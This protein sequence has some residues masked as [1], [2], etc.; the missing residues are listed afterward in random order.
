MLR[1]QKD[2]A[3]AEKLEGKT[4]IGHLAKASKD[5][6]A[7]VQEWLAVLARCFQLQEAIAVLELDRVLDSAPEELDNHRLALCAARQ[8]RLD[9]I[10]GSTRRLMDRLDAAGGMANTKVLLHPTAAGS[11]VRSSNQVALTVVDVQERLGI[12]GGRE[13][14]EARRWTDAAAE[15]KVKAF[16]AGSDGIDAA[17]RFGDE[18][19]GRA[20]SVT[21]RFSSGF[22]ERT[23]RRRTDDQNGGEE[24]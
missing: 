20:K 11:V 1:A 19:F 12:T 3:R 24:G 14:L 23:R 2:S 21:G 5:A 17:K 16:E 6:E 8:N 15:V 22:A 13:S 9:L 18:S 10:S 4:N 7:V